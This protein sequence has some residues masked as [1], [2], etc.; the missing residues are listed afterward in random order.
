MTRGLRDG[1]RALRLADGTWLIRSGCCR[2]ASCAPAADARCC[3][4][5]RCDC[6]WPHALNAGTARYLN[7]SPRGNARATRY[8]VRSWTAQ[9]APRSRWVAAIAAGVTSGLALCG[10]GAWVITTYWE[11]AIIGV[12]VAAGVLAAIATRGRRGSGSC[13][14]TFTHRHAGGR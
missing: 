4:S 11:T 3:L 5:A 9:P 12:V 2:P 6:D 14:S 7:D 1:T 10:F 8:P 13:E